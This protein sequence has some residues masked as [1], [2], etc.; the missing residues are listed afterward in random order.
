MPSSRQDRLEAQAD[1]VEAVLLSHKIRATVEG[2]AMTPRLIRF[3]LSPAAGVRI[4]QIARLSEEL[5]LALGSVSC[6]V[7]RRGEQVHLEFPR[8]GR[9]IVRLTTLLN[10]LP[11]PPSATAVLGLDAD[12]APML[13][14]LP[15]PDVA[16]VLIAGTTGSGKTALAQ[17]MIASLIQTN[18]LSELGLALIDPKG[19]GYAPFVDAPHLLRPIADDPA[20]AL[21]ALQ[22]LVREMERRD[23][24]RITLPRMMVFIDELA[25]LMMVGGKDFE[26]ALTRLV[27]RGREAGIHVIACT[28]RPSATVIGSLVKSNFPVRI[29]GSVTS[30]EDARVATGIAGSG[31]ERLTGRGDFLVV[32]HGVAHRLQAAYIA[33]PEIELLLTRLNGRLAP[34]PAQRVSSSP[35]RVRWLD[36]IRSRLVEPLKRAVGE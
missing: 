20:R 35:L 23:H 6:R 31:A 30:P 1:Q 33:P 26:R 25:D 11:N 4:A 34:S 12:G 36:E 10:Q 24:Q 19:R 18:S 9:R 29:V 32:A 27:Q 3:R 21:N 7:I 28:Q 13:L 15:S 8:P 14:R 22:W 5:A 17:T 2:G 16:H